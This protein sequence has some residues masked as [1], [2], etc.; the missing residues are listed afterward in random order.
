MM[1]RLHWERT[2]KRLWCRGHA[3]CVAASLLT[4]LLVVGCGGGEHE[5][6]ARHHSVLD[7]LNE[8][9]QPNDNAGLSSERWIEGVDY[10]P[11]QGMAL[12]DVDTFYVENRTGKIERFPC[13]E[14]H[15][16]PL[17]EMKSSD[18]AFKRAHWELSLH[19]APSDVMSCATCHDRDAL[20]SLTL[21][22]GNRVSFNQSYRLCAGCHSSQA[23]DWIG[24]AHGKRIGG[25][26]APRI[27]NSCVSCHNPHDPSW[28][29][30]FP[31]R[32]SRI[33]E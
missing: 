5:T 4:L 22:G 19:H 30:R 7:R 1:S 27:I 23:Q 11:V 24:G 17:A 28:K 2:E 15:T 16:L 33:T 21:L 10:A 25:W 14:C 6:P 29:P 32:A 9:D 18:T 13:S 8:A 20:D 3:Q 31:A 12:G 26:A